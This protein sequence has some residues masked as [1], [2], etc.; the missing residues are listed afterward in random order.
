MK[1]SLQAMVSGAW[2]RNHGLSARVG[3]AVTLHYDLMHCHVYSGCAVFAEAWWYER[4]GGHQIREDSFPVAAMP[5]MIM[6]RGSQLRP[7][8]HCKHLVRTR[9]EAA[10]TRSGQGALLLF[11]IS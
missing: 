1:F 4:P 7:S 2:R 6:H 8:S 10:G 11:E 3:H 5:L 9:G